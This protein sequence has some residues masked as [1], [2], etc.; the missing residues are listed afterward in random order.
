MNELRELSK[1]QPDGKVNKFK[2]GF[3]NEKLADA[4]GILGSQWKPLRT[5]EQFDVDD[6]PS[7]SDVVLILSQYT[8]ALTR[9]QH[10]NTYS[11][12][13]IGRMWRTEPPTEVD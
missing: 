12:G 2:L 8:G 11:D 4:N 6:L 7:N 10:D 5:F 13:L 1:K 9:W 3:I